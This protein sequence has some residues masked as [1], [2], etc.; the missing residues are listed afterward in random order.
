MAES[1]FVELSLL[2]ISAVVIIWL[3]RMLKQ[4]LIIGYI[5]TGI[6]ASPT[7]LNL[8]KSTE[9]ITTFSEIG[10][11]L[12]LFMVGLGL[13]PK[14]IKD[15]G[16]ISLITGIGQVL[17]TSIIGFIILKALGFNIL[18]SIYV[19][20][21]LT[22]SSTII[23]MK[24]LSDKGDLETLYGKISIGFLIVQDLIAILILMI[25]SSFSEGGNILSTITKSLL[26]GSILLISIFIFSYIALPR[27]TKS[28]AKSQEFL[29]LFSL[30]WCMAIAVLF[31]IFNF[32]IEIGALV[33]GVT[34]SISPFR[35][36]ISSKLK[37]LR[38]F[39]IFT[40]F[41]WLGS[42]MTFTSLGNDIP[43]III[44]SLFILIGNPLIVIILMGAMKYKKQT[45]F[46]AGLT[47]AQISE[48]SLILIAL[49]VKVGHLAPET[50][51][52]VTFVGIITI[53]GSTYFIMYSHKLYPHIAPLLSKLERHPTNKE[54]ARQIKYD[55]ILFGAHRT[56]SKIINSLK[57]NRNSLLVIDFNPDVIENLSKNG[58]NTIYG[59]LSDSDL[60]EQLSL[61]KAKMI[62]S[63]IPDLESNL[64]LLRKLKEK[65]NKSIILTAT[66][67][68]N[69]RKLYKEGA[70]Y[71]I[72]PQMLAGEYIAEIIR[73][74]KT[75]QSKYKSLG[76]A[77]IKE[78]LKKTNAFS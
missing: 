45:S 70:D 18:T 65:N 12:L 69:A 26:T 27:I 68:H 24:L 49:G 53:A 42:K 77:H 46:L 29:L 52:L 8:A 32:S 21:A 71:V 59:D 76:K 4:P 37:P 61:E 3:V 23:I 43:S 48:F 22:F 39:F 33:A 16:K 73:E 64:I 2:I 47:V 10:V 55:I 44:L 75:S 62:I 74:N 67:I 31:D 60:L 56:G 34:L 66:Q 54:S 63:T 40:F 5:V 19:S 11:A 28:I 17:F 57:K 15:V 72:I 1:F 13:N 30:G 9:I 14:I 6:I 51:S 41:I 7:I 38:D 78:L 50:L 35:Y 36:E 20:I 58:Y 25:I